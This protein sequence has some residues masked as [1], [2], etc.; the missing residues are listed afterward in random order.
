MTPQTIQYL[1][2]IF[3]RGN[4]EKSNR[5][6]ADRVQLFIREEIARQNWYEQSI[7]SE[8]RITSFFSMTL[9]SQHNLITLSIETVERE[10]EATALL[11]NIE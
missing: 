8:T 2:D 4:T 5:T 3:V 6:S 9:T 7:V 1:H 10:N 11:L